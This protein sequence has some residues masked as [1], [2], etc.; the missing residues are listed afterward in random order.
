MIAF[1]A[2][3][4]AMAVAGPVYADSAADGSTGGSPGLISGNG[5]QLPVHLPVNVCGNTVNVV[6]LLNPAHGNSCANVG[7][8]TKKNGKDT[9]AGATTTGGATAKGS[10]QGSPGLISGNGIQL[11]VDLPVNVSGNSV[12][13]VGIG[14]P[15]FG[16]TSVNTSDEHP[17][18]PA[19]QPPTRVVPPVHTKPPVR[20]HHPSTVRSTP[21]PDPVVVRHQPVGTLAQTGADGTWAAAGASLALLA[22]GAV[23]YRRAR[24]GTAGRQG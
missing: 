20:A 11:P 24:S 14:N 19:T 17:D 15:V 1:A 3:S 13:V 9:K 22:G 2:V 6:G 18:E 4:G 21:K 12:N 23:L 5:I 8:A 16:N 7:K 10:T